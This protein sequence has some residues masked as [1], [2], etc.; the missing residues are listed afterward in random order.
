MIEA[1]TATSLSFQFMS[2]H[3]IYIM[4]RSLEGN[5]TEKPKVGCRFL[6]Y[7]EKGLKKKIVQLMV[8]GDI[9]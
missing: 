3:F 5:L 6:I 7:W 8:R 1:T 9:N 2:S 4:P